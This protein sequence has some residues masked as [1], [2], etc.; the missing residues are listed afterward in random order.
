MI[1]DIGHAVQTPE[2][3]T[4]RNISGGLS[5]RE[6]VFIVDKVKGVTPLFVLFELQKLNQLVS[7]KVPDHLLLALL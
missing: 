3:L 2:E 5:N 4:M 6:G 1:S 7:I